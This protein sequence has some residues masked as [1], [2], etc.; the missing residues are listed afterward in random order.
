MTKITVLILLGVFATTLSFGQAK[1]GDFVAAAHTR[2][3]L[4]WGGFAG[5]VL[6]AKG[7]I[8]GGYMLTDNLEVGLQV[9]GQAAFYDLTNPLLGI[10]LGTYAQYYFNA[11]GKWQ[12]YV[13]GGLTYNGFLFNSTTINGGV[14]ETVQQRGLYANL[15][16]G[17]QRWMTDDLAIFTEL[18]YQRALVGESTRFDLL[19]KGHGPSIGIR[20]T[21]RR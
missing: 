18:E 7:G 20:W 8:Q 16:I 3:G 13:F 9:R 5:V 15:G 10:D 19:D 17:L 4:G 2:S 12:P 6:Q 14:I 11:G 1:K 21:P